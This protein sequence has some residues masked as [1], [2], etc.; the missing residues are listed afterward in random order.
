MRFVDTRR[1]C[2]QTR[3]TNW[4][5]LRKGRPVAEM[6]A[7]LPPMIGGAIACCAAGEVGVATLCARQIC[8][9]APGTETDSYEQSM[10]PPS[11]LALIRMPAVCPAIW[12]HEITGQHTVSQLS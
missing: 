3:P 6:K 4:D 8:S 9:V 7:A 11:G 10:P 2:G 5:A 12:S 1:I